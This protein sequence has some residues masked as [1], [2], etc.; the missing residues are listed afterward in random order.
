MHIIPNALSR[1]ASREET[2]RSTNMGELEVL[3]ATVQEIWANP[4]ML[5]KLSSDFKQKLK[6]GY[7]NDPGWKRVKDIVTRNENLKAEAAKL[8]Y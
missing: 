6:T 1:L 3:V 7:E 2:A 8:F 5:V 4:A